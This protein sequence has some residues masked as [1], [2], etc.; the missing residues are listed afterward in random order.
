MSK[1]FEAIEACISFAD[2]PNEGSPVCKQARAELAAMRE[3]VEA[4]NLLVNGEG[5]GTV[6]RYKNYQ[7]VR[8]A[9]ANC[10][11]VTAKKAGGR[12]E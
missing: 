9:L 8:D 7:K 3:L 6:G 11:R 1:P 12:R 4:A 5:I 10:K 2:L